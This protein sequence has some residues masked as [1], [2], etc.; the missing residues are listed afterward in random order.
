M[1]NILCAKVGPHHKYAVVLQDALKCNDE[2]LLN[3][4]A[5]IDL[6]CRDPEIQRLYFPVHID[7]LK[8]ATWCRH[9]L[10]RYA[11]P[12]SKDVWDVYWASNE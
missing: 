8:Q 11:A 7:A 4:D 9:E 3:I 5:I 2:A 12:C 6:V 10:C 1:N